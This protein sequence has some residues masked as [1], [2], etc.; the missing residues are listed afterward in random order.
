MEVKTGDDDVHTE[1]YSVYRKVRFEGLNRNAITSSKHEGSSDAYRLVE[2]RQW[3]VR[4]AS[5]SPV[6]ADIGGKY[7]QHLITRSEEQLRW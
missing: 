4:S 6:L 5:V 2:A 7:S 1:L 3:D